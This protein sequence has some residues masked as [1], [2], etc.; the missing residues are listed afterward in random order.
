M[1][2]GRIR[3]VAGVLAV[4][5]SL[6]LAGTV[7]AQPQPKQPQQ[8]QPKQTPQLSAIAPLLPKELLAKEIIVAKGAMQIYEPVVPGLV[9]RAKGV[10]LQQNPML[11][12]DLN[13]VAARLRTELAPRTTELIN[14]AARLYAAAFTEQEL[15]DIL[16]FYK[17]P[18]GKKV[19]A[20][21][22]MILD[23]SVSNVDAWGAK[24]ADEVLG[25][26][27]IEMKKKGHDL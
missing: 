22:P 25:K 27:R 24:F 5:L 16:A 6:A 17:S 11:G 3:S 7:L 8:P 20:E 4:G 10:F 23:K 14:D 2:V 15:K 21:E 12:R 19:I 1:V 13:E 9:E 26:F 18:V